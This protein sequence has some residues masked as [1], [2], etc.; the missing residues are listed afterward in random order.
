VLVPPG[1]Y[2]FVVEP[3]KAAFTAGSSVGPYA[4]G[5]LDLSFVKPITRKK[6]GKVFTVTAG[7]VTDVGVMVM[8]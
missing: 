7:A 8:P 5:P 1:S 4:S 3:I 2:L 6:F